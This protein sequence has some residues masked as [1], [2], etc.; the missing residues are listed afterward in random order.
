MLHPVLFYTHQTFITCYPL[1]QIYL[2]VMGWKNPP[3]CTHYRIIHP[4]C[5]CNSQTTCDVEVMDETAMGGCGG[6]WACHYVP[7]WAG[8]I[9][10]HCKVLPEDLLAPSL[11]PWYPQWQGWVLFSFPRPWCVPGNQGG[12]W[13]SECTPKSAALTWSPGLSRAN[14]LCWVSHAEKSLQD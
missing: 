3:C 9:Y 10:Q 13:Q 1:I 12:E 11:L 2:T 7:I 14:L 6:L 5:K 4:Q 8:A